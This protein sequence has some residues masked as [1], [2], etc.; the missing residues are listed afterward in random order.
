MFRNYLKTAFRSLG[1]QKAYSLINVFGLTLGIT[2]CLIIFLVVKYELSY[3]LFNKKADRIYRVTLNAIDFNPSVSMVVTPAMRN[4]FPELEK[5]SQVWWRSTGLVRIGDRRFEEKGYAY[6]DRYFPQIFDYDWL[7]GDAKTALIEPNAVVL[8]QSVATKYFGDADPMGKVIRLNNAHDLK[9]TGLIRDVPGN[10]HLPFGFLVSFE[11]MRE[12]LKRFSPGFFSIAGANTYILLPEN[13]SGAQLQ[14]R[15]PAFISKNWGRENVSGNVLRLQ[16]LTEI[17]YDQRYLDNPASPTTSRQTYHALA[18]VGVFIILIACINFVNLATAQTMRRNKEVGVR[19]VLGSSRAQLIRQFMLET[20]VMVLIAAVLSV[21]LVSALMPAVADLLDIRITVA[22]LADPL[23]IGLLISIIIFVILCAGMY[24]AFVQSAFSPVSA[25]RNNAVTPGMGL[26]VR[27]GLVLVQ[28]C[29][30]QI[31]IIGTLIVAWQMDYFQNQDLGFNKDAVIDMPMP[32]GAKQ[33]V[34]R[35]RLMDIPGVKT[36]SFSSGAPAYSASFADFNSPETGMTKG[37]VTEIK[38]VDEKYF[39]MFGLEMLAGEKVQKMSARDSI[40]QVVVNETLLHKMH[41]QSP[42]KAI[43]KPIFINGTRVNVAGVTHDFQSESKHK[44]RRPCILLYSPKSFYR[45]SIKMQPGN[46]RETIGRVDKTWS[47]TF[48]EELFSYEFLDEHIA[49]MYRQEQK[50]Y[51]AFKLFS[52]IAIFIGCLGLYGLMAFSTAQRRKEVGVRK[53]LGASLGNIVLLF[54]RE[55]V[56][57][58][59]LAFI[60]AAPLSYFVMHNWLQNFAYHISIG[61]GVFLIAVAV[62][63]IIAACTIVFQSLRAGMVNPVKSLRTE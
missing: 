56:L 44:L 7:E 23:V 42:G 46:M 8:T 54:S 63:F 27:K 24:P 48:P 1:R 39:D 43:G 57:L 4:D 28:F 13:L 32:D 60:A 11:T 26:F 12:D 31:L 40:Y 58:I 29:I 14:K 37:D 15:M 19:K 9:V 53:V 49:G 45:L 20:T 61:A 50:Q 10:T 2:S 33:D 52:G 17:H 62:S 18:A 47:A 35:N 51:I 6:A 59:G 25:F 41:L 21:M 3:D 34:L 36:V 30:S 55:F 22:Q 16:P 38:Y 5:V